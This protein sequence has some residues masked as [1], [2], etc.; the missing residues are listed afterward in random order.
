MPVVPAVIIQAGVND[1]GSSWNIWTTALA[2][3]IQS[4]DGMLDL[5][6]EYTEMFIG[7]A[8]TFLFMDTADKLSKLL[9]SIQKQ[10]PF[11]FESLDCHC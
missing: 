4:K 1:S 5:G 7:K 9:K 11:E 8:R 6:K 10:I 2:A 3:H